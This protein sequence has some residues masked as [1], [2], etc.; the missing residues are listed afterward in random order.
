M[1]PRAILAIN[2]GSSSL[3]LAAFD[4][5]SL[6][7]LGAV[8]EH[9]AADLERGIAT[10]VAQIGDGDVAWHAIG[11]RVTNGGDALGP[12][13][14]DDARVAALARLA[15]FAPQHQPINLA[16]IAAARRLAPHVPQ[17]ACYDT[18]FHRTIPDVAR[19]YAIPRALADE[20]IAVFGYH[21]LSYEHVAGNDGPRARG[22]E[23]SAIA[24]RRRRPRPRSRVPDRTA[25]RATE[26][27]AAG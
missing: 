10:L 13:R 25:P 11:H 22:G 16:C 18:A 5:T 15:P 24:P 2:A 3:K 12:E 19:H 1:P 9:G 21:G 20:G 14:I 27:R 23:T 4:A 6:A 7:R 17:V 8:H 26:A